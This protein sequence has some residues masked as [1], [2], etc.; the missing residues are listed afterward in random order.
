MDAWEIIMIISII[1]SLVSVISVTWGILQ[2]KRSDRI[3]NTIRRENE[4]LN[5]YLKTEIPSDI[6]ERYI[7]N[8]NNFRYTN[9]DYENIESIFYEIRK[10]RKDL[11]KFNELRVT[12]IKELI[13][14]NS[15]SNEF[16]YKQ[17]VYQI[18]QMTN[19]QYLF[20]LLS[21]NK[22]QELN[23]VKNVLAD[24]VHTIR[25]PASGMRAIIT[26]L[27]MDNVD[28]QF[29]E[30]LDD[31]E[32]FINEIETNLNAYYQISHT[33]PVVLDNNKIDFKDEVISRA[34][35][36]SLS[37]GKKVNMEH[38]RICE[39]VI[40]KSVSEIL[41]LAI[42]CI[43]ENSISFIKDNGIIEIGIENDEN[44]LTIQI[45]NNGPSIQEEFIKNVFD[46]GFSTRA[47]SGRGLAIAK[48][49]VESTLNG[50]ITC[51]NLDNDSGVKFS[52]VV[53]M[54]SEDE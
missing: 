49:A 28:E 36:L 52:I 30:K 3:V 16:D 4:A 54:S 9:F 34:R 42:T 47:S 11:Q 7:S 39:V 50:I 25:N 27:K 20:E 18:S 13:N 31:I 14:D 8:L 12:E 43:L 29:A 40:D 6:R 53:E 32:K 45:S 51:E 38:N 33:Q 10:I 21:E 15:S 26:I 2:R 17:L 48:Q 22:D 23:Y 41:M 19:I 46:Q 5:Y 44:I 1:A 24:I 37:S 35:L